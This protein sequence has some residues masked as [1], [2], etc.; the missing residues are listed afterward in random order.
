MAVIPLDSVAAMRQPRLQRP[1][2]ASGAHEV[3]PPAMSASQILQHLYSLDT[4]SDISRLI[5]DL[6]R[7]DDEEQYLSSLQGSE[8]A[9]LID[10]LDKVR[11]PLPASHLVMK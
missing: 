1:P 10:F 3:D 4:S 7:H 2:V 11:T 9:Q 5:R 8:L 6:I